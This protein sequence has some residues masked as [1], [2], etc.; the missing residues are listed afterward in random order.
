M[1]P[2]AE[3]FTGRRLSAALGQVVAQLE[4][5]PPVGP[6]TVGDI[7]DLIGRD[8]P[9][10]NARVLAKRLARRGWLHRLGRGLYEFV[11]AAGVLPSGSPWL[12]LT[13]LA[14][15]YRVSGI[16]AAAHHRLTT[17][18]PGRRLLVM[19][20]SAS[21]PTRLDQSPAFRIAQVKDER[22]G[23]AAP[24]VIDGVQVQMATLERTV[25]DAIQHPGWFG[26]IGEA[27]R[28]ITRGVPRAD[29]DTLISEA[30]ADPRVAAQR[31][32]WWLE[33]LRALSHDQRSALRAAIG[34]HPSDQ[35]LVPGAA[36][37]GRHD[38]TW[39]LII[40]AD[41]DAGSGEEQVR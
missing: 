10:E 5:N 3:Q 21:V 26:G 41:A 36:R 9:R 29:A 15:P 34:T 27:Q 38:A 1:D 18:L 33:Q 28:V 16:A 6:L 39:H 40:N 8:K 23:T 7:H 4:A 31:V 17:Q 35:P 30:G 11:P 12:L 25:L 13:E 37:R 32:G 2:N 22:I 20:R 19:P 24:V 14:M